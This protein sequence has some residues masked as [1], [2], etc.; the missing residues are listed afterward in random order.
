MAE[1]E[2]GCGSYRGSLRCC[3]H[4]ADLTTLSTS[5]YPELGIMGINVENNE[6]GKPANGG[7]DG[8]L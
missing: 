5:T 7:A 8:G 3:T 4:S 6:T 2:P 1:R